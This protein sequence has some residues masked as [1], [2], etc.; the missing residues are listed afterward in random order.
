MKII[1]YFANQMHN[2]FGVVIFD[3]L[4]NI[5]IDVQRAANTVRDGKAA[6]KKY[7]PEV[8]CASAQI[9]RVNRKREAIT[10]KAFNALE[11]INIINA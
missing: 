9:Y 7:A 5:A 8:P 3:V 4:G 1:P 2:R 6:I 10:V 11:V